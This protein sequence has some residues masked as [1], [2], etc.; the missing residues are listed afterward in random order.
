MA[1]LVLSPMSTLVPILRRAWMSK[2]EK[3]K[4]G[5]AGR[6][7]PQT[8]QARR[9]ERRREGGQYAADAAGTQRGW[10][11]GAAEGWV[12]TDQHGWQDTGQGGEVDGCLDH[13]GLGWQGE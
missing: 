4:E 11:S 7:T 6:R 9:G 8:P 5:G 1:K 3:K 12:W 13:S 10:R 2:G